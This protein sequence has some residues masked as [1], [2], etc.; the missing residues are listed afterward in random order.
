[1]KKEPGADAVIDGGQTKNPSVNDFLQ[2]FDEINADNVF[3]LPNNPNIFMS[4]NTAA[5]LYKDSK[6]YV[7]PSTNIG[8]AYAALSML[9]YTGTAD[10]IAERMQSDAQDVT[11]GMVT[12]SVRDADINGVKI[13]KG[14]YVGF[15]D[16]TMLTCKKG[17][18]DAAIDLISK[19]DGA[20]KVLLTAVYGVSATEEDRNEL[21]NRVKENFP[22]I[23]MYEIDG[24][25]EVYDFILI[26]E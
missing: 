17:K 5:E 6:I 21:K 14:N 1:M 2:A 8:Q 11:T 13:I 22:D 19:L 16:K 7:V 4:A 10:E 18:V 12:T 15:T 24:G 9:D 23:E 26:I 25:Q 20:E 3:V